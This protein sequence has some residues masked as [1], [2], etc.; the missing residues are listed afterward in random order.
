MDKN[1]N[2]EIVIIGF[3]SSALEQWIQEKGIE[4]IASN[5]R[6]IEL[7]YI[8]HYF[9]SRFIKLNNTLKQLNN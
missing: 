4:I 1:C 6:V 3:P 2:Q 9:T 5:E 7:Q 8:G